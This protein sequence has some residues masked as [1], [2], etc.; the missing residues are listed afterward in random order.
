MVAE[1]SRQWPSWKVLFSPEIATGCHR[2][3]RRRRVLCLDR[4][5]A[6]DVLSNDLHQLP[7][8]SAAGCG[9]RLALNGMRFANLT[10]INSQEYRG[11]I[12]EFVVG[13]FCNPLVNR[14]SRA[15]MV[16]EIRQRQ[17]RPTDAPSPAPVRNRVCSGQGFWHP[18]PH[19]L[20]RFLP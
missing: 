13:G 12:S 7:I 5:I 17:N 9:L 1:D 18:R 20:V 11:S 6:E 15:E 16:Y 10:K 14:T 19:A 4:R 8:L 3:Q 2:H